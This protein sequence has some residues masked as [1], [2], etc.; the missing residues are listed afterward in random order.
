MKQF[1][2]YTTVGGTYSSKPRPSV[3]IQSVVEEFDSITILPMTS[4]WLES[5]FRIEVVPSNDNGLEAISYVMIDKLTTIKKSGLGGFIGHMDARYIEQI[6]ARLLEFVGLDTLKSH[7][8][9]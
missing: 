8:S 3:I 7:N 4:D 6:K 2:I 1:D 9:E 5:V